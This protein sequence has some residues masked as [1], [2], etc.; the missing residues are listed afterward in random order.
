[1]NNAAYTTIVIKIKKTFILPFNS[2]NNFGIAI[3]TNTQNGYEILP[4][5]L[6]NI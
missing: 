4:A 6:S 5:A 1:M 3:K 2:S